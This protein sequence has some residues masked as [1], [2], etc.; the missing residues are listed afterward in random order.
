MWWAAANPPSSGGLSPRYEN[1]AIE[2]KNSSASLELFADF[3][4]FDVLRIRKSVRA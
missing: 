4:K 2:Q 1:V 3:W